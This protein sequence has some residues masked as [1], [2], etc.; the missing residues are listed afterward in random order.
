M[1][2]LI[3]K[4]LDGTATAEE[5][6]QLRIW[7]TASPSNERL[8]QELS[9]LW[10]ALVETGT[11]DVAPPPEAQELIRRAGIRPFPMRSWRKRHQGWWWIG[12]AAA[13]TF[14]VTGTLAVSRVLGSSK[15]V[16]GFGADEFVT[17][18][19]GVSTVTLRDGTVV[20]LG[21]HSRLGL[22]GLQSDREVQLEGR[23]FFA[24]AHAPERP[25]RILTSAGT[26]T[27]LGTRFDLQVGGDNLNLALLEGRV[28]LKTP[29]KEVALRAGQATRVVQGTT[30]P[31]SRIADRDS[32]M[33]WVGDFLAF[34]ET[35]LG[36]AA[37][38]IERHYN[39]RILISDPSLASR[40]ISAWF[41]DRPVEE[42]LR[43]V[44]AATLTECS[45]KDGDVMVRPLR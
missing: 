23:A 15:A 34:Q 26:V 11:R 20:R 44:C 10:I 21:P 12:A 41:T 13:A 2:P 14:L 1:E 4:S 30:L 36:E 7:R 8:Y 19:S 22:T 25:F 37:R 33:S 35:P 29:G 5:E 6:H 43:I 24:V 27:A 42:V 17:G 31:V 39:V 45:M 28:V 3:L 16:V 9:R 18:A 32:A 38:E 40:A